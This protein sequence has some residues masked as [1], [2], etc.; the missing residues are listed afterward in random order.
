MSKK[1]VHNIKE[2]NQIVRLKLCFCHNSYYH[3]DVKP[4]IHFNSQS[5]N[6]LFCSDLNYD[7]SIR[8]E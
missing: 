5:L 6:K 4:I 1:N 2:K 7:S 8:D 3:N